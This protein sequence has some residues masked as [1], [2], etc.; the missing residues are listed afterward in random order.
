MVIGTGT[1][2]PGGRFAFPRSYINDF[3]V[4]RNGDTIAQTGAKFVVTD[5]FNPN[6]TATFVML[7]QMFVWNTNTYTM[8][9]VIVESYYQNT[10]GGDKFPL[11]YNLNYSID[12]ANGRSRLIL[13]WSGFMTD[14]QKMSFPPQQA[15][16]WLPVPLP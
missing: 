1:F 3:Y 13:G 4:C 16:Y 10:I 12:P 15:D 9:H 5:T 6:L 14:P 7:L 2:V 11:P 8:D